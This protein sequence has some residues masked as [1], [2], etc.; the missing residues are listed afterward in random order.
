MRHN[1][2]H[3]DIWLYSLNC[4]SRIPEILLKVWVRRKKDILGFRVHTHFYYKYSDCVWYR[5]R[6]GL[7]FE[8]SD[9]NGKKC[10]RINE[11]VRYRNMEMIV[12]CQQ[13]KSS[14]S[15]I[16]CSFKTTPQLVVIHNSWTFITLS[17]LWA[18][19]YPMHCM[20][21]ELLHAAAPIHSYS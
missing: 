15:L 11:L 4:T 7:A 8:V 21:H 3:E 9:F 13:K 18:M 17:E 2:I 5:N 1:E 6:S 19:S 16:L 20:M 14:H 12:D 10:L